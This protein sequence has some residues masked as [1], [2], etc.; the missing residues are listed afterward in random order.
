M[1]NKIIN[2]LNFYGFMNK[3]NKKRCSWPDE[4][5]F[6]MIEYH[7]KEWGTPCHDDKKLF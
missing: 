5:D 7:D 4:K 2:D 1:Y 3:P 6:L